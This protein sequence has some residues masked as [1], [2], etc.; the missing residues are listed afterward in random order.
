MFNKICNLFSSFFNY[1]KK[2]NME[3]EILEQPEII[4]KLLRRYLKL[5]FEIDIEVPENIQNTVFIASGS[6]YHSASIITEFINS[7][8]DSFAKAYYSSEVCLD[9]NFNVKDNTLYVFISQSGETKDTNEA[10]NIISQKT[11]NIFAISNTKSSTLYNSAKYKI[12]IQAGIE[13]SIA[14]TKAMSAQTFCLF[15]LALKL[16]K[17]HNINV[18]HHIDNL[19][20]VPEAI[21]EAIKKHKD[22]ISFAKQFY[23]CENII[24]LANSIYYRLSQ[25]GALKIQEL[26]YINSSAYPFGEFMHGHMAVLNKKSAVISLINSVNSLVAIDLLNKLSSKY[27]FENLVITNI[28]LND[29]LKQSSIELKYDNIS[30]IF[31]AL[32]LFQLLSLEIS[33]ALNRNTDSPQ[34]LSKIVK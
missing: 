33:K 17:M 28:N 10:M 16:L 2:S 1:S 26:S 21:E 11:A 15:L 3:K 24:L 34:G 32:V 18:T 13:K 27:N 7:Q 12:Y 14:S 4:S 29:N 25:E 31:S 5:N 19:L 6:S 30:F 8:L 22:I 20:T 9:K 23:T